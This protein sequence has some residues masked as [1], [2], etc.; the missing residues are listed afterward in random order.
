MHLYSAFPKL[1]SFFVYQLNVFFTKNN[2]N[3]YIVSIHL[4]WHYY[5]HVNNQTNQITDWEAVV[6]AT[7]TT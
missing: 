7:S 6:I 4:R 3:K 2:L 1:F 5:Y